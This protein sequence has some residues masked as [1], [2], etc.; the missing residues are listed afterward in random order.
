MAAE[1]RPFTGV[2]YFGLMLTPDGPKVLEYNTRFGDPETQ[3]VLPRM[4]TDIVD[5]MDACIDGTLDQ[6]LTT[7]TAITASTRG[8]NLTIMAMS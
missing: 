4:K 7:R 1:G 8:L 2:L 3:V 5:V 6:D